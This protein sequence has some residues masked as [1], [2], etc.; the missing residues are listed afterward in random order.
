M[1]CGGQALDIQSCARVLCRYHTKKKIS[2]AQESCTSLYIR[3]KERQ[4]VL[5]DGRQNLLCRNPQKHTHPEILHVC[6]IT[7]TDHTKGLS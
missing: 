3:E 5:Q 1:H 2:N 4:K 7:F 6:N